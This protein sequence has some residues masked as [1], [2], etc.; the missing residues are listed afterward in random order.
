[1]PEERGLYPKMRV[2]DQLSYLARLHGAA[3]DAAVAAAERWAT[4]LGLEER[5]DSRIE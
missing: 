1:M 3:S 2:R 4:A 5:M